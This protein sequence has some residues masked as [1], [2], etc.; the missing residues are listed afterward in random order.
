MSALSIFLRTLPDALHTEL[1]SRTFN[2]LLKGQ[3]MLDQL[4]DLEGKRIAIGITDSKTELLFLVKERRLVRSK[5][6]DAP[7]GHDVRIAGTLE[8]FWKLATRAEDPDTLFFNRQLTIEG[9]TETGLFVKN[10][11][12]SLDFDP[13]LHLNAVLGERLG[14]RAFQLLNKSG[15]DSKL[16]HKFDIP[17]IN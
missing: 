8:S 10:M 13:E 11:L 7:A 4:E 9:E 3:W 1:F 17:Q 14:K 5:L 12:D 6:K 15:I 16:R 2:H